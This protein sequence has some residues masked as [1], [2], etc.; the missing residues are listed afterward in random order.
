MQ[1]KAQ[2]QAQLHQKQ[3]LDAFSLLNEKVDA[4]L[5][6]LGL[7]YYDSGS[8]DTE[9]VQ[10]KAG[11]INQYWQGAWQSRWYNR[12][13]DDYQNEEQQQD[14]EIKALYE[15]ADLMRKQRLA[16]EEQEAQMKALLLEEMKSQTSTLTIPPAKAT[17][18]PT[19]LPNPLPKQLQIAVVRQA[20]IRKVRFTK[21]E[22]L[23][24]RLFPNMTLILM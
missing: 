6:H 14:Q 24:K 15:H 10:W 7:E 13:H 9:Q 19:M 3:L 20:R 1:K 8:E 18:S 11:Q 5:N 16:L 21:I 17:A 23:P 4:I 22:R 12:W 2:R